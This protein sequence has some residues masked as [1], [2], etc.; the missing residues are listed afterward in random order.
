MI[1]RTSQRRWCRNAVHPVRRWEFY[2]IVVI[3]APV[4]HDETLPVLSPMRYISKTLQRVGPCG[5]ACQPHFAAMYGKHEARRP[6]E[7]EQPCKRAFSGSMMVVVWGNLCCMA[8]Y[9]VPRFAS[10]PEK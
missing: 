8:S 3:E 4:R 10:K 2:G 6:A 7:A 9:Q 5:R 1:G